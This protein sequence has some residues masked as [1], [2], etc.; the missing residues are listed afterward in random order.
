MPIIDFR[1][2]N[3]ACIGQRHRHVFVFL[4]QPAQCIE[5]LIDSE[6]DAQRPILHEL[7]DGVL[8]AMRV[9]YVNAVAS[10][11][12]EVIPHHAARHELRLARRI[13]RTRI[14]GGAREQLFGR[15]PVVEMV[16]LPRELHAINPGL[17][18]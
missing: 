5:M 14:D 4:K 6:C 7:R 12:K 15:R 16:G 8:L 11:M 17:A 9:R 18:G 3:D 10:S 1:H 13:M 2:T